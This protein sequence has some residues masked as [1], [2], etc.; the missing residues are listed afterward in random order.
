[1]TFSSYRL[2]LA[3]M[4]FMFFLLILMGSAARAVT[5][6]EKSAECTRL[7][8]LEKELGCPA[9]PQDLAPPAATGDKPERLTL[10]KTFGPTKCVVQSLLETEKK[11][12]ED[13]C[14]DWTKKQ[15]TRLKTKFISGN[16]DETCAPCPKNE[17]LSQ[18][19]FKGEVQYYSK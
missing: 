19:T 1:M 3:G 11:S 14:E 6:A 5:P 12:T 18:C 4:A 2:S 17:I 16:C 7:W 15:E 8:S 9:M 13:K 10:N